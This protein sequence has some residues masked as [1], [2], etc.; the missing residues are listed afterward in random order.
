MARSTTPSPSRLDDI[1]ERQDPMRWGVNYM[2]GQLGTKQESPDASRPGTIYSD[3][4]KRLIHVMS[5]P[6]RYAVLLGLY[7]GQVGE[8]HEGR[9]IHCEPA[10]G[11]LTGYEPA[12]SYP[13]VGHSGTIEVADRLGLLRWHPTIQVPDK[14]DSKKKVTVAYPLLGDLLWYFHL[15]T[16]IR[17][18]NWTVKDEDEDFETPF[19]G[20]WPE[21]KPTTN[22]IEVA[23]AR[24]LIEAATYLEVKV[25]T[26]R[27]ALASIPL[28]L[29]ENLRS[30][31]KHQRHPCA[32]DE[33]LRQDFIGDLCLHLPNTV[34]IF[35]TTR[36]YLSRHGGT[37][38]DYKLAANHAIWSK[39]LRIDLTRPFCFDVPVRP[40]P[41]DMLSQFR[42][43]FDPAEV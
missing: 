17:C 21:K 28:H 27:V 1:L 24:P 26:V 29:R 5:D 23:K 3:T 12:N 13:M 8:L 38:Y 14:A 36:A 22:Q 39:Q 11:P 32:L 9:M 2:P 35:E 4:L 33:S 7:G 10:A 18:V 41:T 31:F 19:E 40:A 30:V 37:L 15:P 42:S 20:E 43:W 16:R 25:P 34:S 6:E